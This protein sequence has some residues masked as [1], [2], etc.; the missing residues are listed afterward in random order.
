MEVIATRL[1][2]KKTI[3]E[4]CFSDYLLS[5]SSSRGV[6]FSEVIDV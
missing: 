4:V 3:S 1:F 6:A 5:I 2:D